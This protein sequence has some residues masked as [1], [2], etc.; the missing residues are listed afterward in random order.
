MVSPRQKVRTD[1]GADQ[2]EAA[3]L[4]GRS[5]IARQS[6]TGLSY[7]M[8]HLGKTAEVECEGVYMLFEPP[9]SQSEA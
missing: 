9:Q 1:A 8:F 6:E 5:G 4:D 2:T 3:A 7:T